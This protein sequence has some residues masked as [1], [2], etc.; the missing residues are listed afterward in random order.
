MSS[1]KPGKPAKAG[2]YWVKTDGGK[3]PV[4]VDLLGN[5][6]YITAPAMLPVKPQAVPDNAKFSDEIKAPPDAAGVDSGGGRD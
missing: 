5:M 6:A 3:Y 4:V 2:F 1:Y